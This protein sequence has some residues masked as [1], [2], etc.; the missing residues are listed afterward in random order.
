MK[1]NVQPKKGKI[2]SGELQEIKFSPF[3]LVPDD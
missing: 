3:L 1:I 2:I